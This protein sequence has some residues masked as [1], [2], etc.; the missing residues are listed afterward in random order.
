VWRGYSNP[1]LTDATTLSSTTISVSNVFGSYEETNNS[2]GTPVEIGVGDY[3]EYDWVIQNY[4][5]T[6]GTPYCFRLV[7]SD[8]SEFTFYTNYAQLITNYS[9]EASVLEKLFEHEHMASTSPWFEFK[10]FDAENEAL[11]YQIQVDTDINF[12]STDIDANSEDNEP[13]FTNILN[14]SDKA[15][16]NNNETIRFKATTTLADDTTYWWRVRAKDP[17]GSNSYGEWSIP[18]AFTSSTTIQFSAWFQT[19]L[20]QFETNTHVGTDA[21]TTDQVSLLIGSTTGSMT[22]SEIDFDWGVVGNAWGEFSWNDTEPGGS[23]ITYF[24]EYFTSTSSWAL[25]PDADLPGSSSG[26]GTS[27]VDL[28]ILNT[29][30]YNLLRLRADFSDA[31]TSPTLQDWSVSWSNRVSIPTLL[32]PFDNEKFNTTTPEF[33]FYSDDPDNDDLEY[34]ISWSTSTDFLSS[35]TRN[36]SI[37]FGFENTDDINDIDHLLVASACKRSARLKYMVILE[38]PI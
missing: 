38:F 26:F 37:D 15:P 25:V 14:E 12:A 19:T 3:A 35:T 27:P 2:T 31:G 21:T 8:L 34:E 24:V 18:R 7:E 36:S 33:T 20:D 30:T 9:P 29:E 32:L 4:N 10:S 16:Y 13:S 11:H 1:S 6:S 5:A 17:D 22:S 28:T 23:A